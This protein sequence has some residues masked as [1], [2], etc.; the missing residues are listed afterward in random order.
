M[1]AKFPRFPR[2]SAEQRSFH[3]LFCRQ[4][5]HSTAPCLLA[6]P[7][8]MPPRRK[9]QAEADRPD[10]SQ[11]DDDDPEI[12]APQQNQAA[13]AAQ[14]PLGAAA[15]N[16]PVPQP[17]IHAAGSPSLLLH[18]A[19]KNILLGRKASLLPNTRRKVQPPPPPPG[20]TKSHTIL[21]TPLTLSRKRT[22]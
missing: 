22:T 3:S 17:V 14:A 16:P 18:R 9:Q 7:W 2:A 15:A 19:T 13:A 12:P 11:S 8:Q 20:R 4:K 10:G 6:F 1:T 21:T 5:L